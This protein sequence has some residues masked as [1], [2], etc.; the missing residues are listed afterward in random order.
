MPLHRLVSGYLAVGA[1][2]EPRPPLSLG[3]ISMDVHGYFHG[4]PDNS[5]CW[6]VRIHL[7]HFKDLYVP[8]SPNTP[9]L[10]RPGRSGCSTASEQKTK[11]LATDRWKWRD[12]WASMI[13][14]PTPRAAE[15]EKYIVPPPACCTDR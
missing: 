12:M 11:P 4:L 8:L 9:T 13:A 10:K 1:H 7:R 15:P 5:V 3:D 6:R 14:V 2:P